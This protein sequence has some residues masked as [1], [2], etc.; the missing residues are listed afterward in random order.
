MKKYFLS[1]LISVLCISNCSAQ[2]ITTFAGNG[3][4]GYSGDG[5]PA[6]IAQLKYSYALAADSQGN[7][8]VGHGSGAVRKVD[9]AGG[10][11]TFAGNGVPGY[12]GD[13]GPATMA[14]IQ[15]IQSMGIDKKGNVFLY[16]G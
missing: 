8:Y 15:A 4:L 16:D 10:I 2:T 13:N 9:T 12:S 7:I 14:Q 6:T 1:L 11:S 5:G 3:T